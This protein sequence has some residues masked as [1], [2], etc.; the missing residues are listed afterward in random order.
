[1]VELLRAHA[2]GGASA[3]GS[4]GGGINTN[5]FSGSTSSSTSSAFG[6]PVKKQQ[7]MA[8]GEAMQKSLPSQKKTPSTSSKLLQEHPP[9]LWGVDLFP[10]WS[11]WFLVEMEKRRLEVCE[12]ERMDQRVD[13]CP[14][15]LSL[16]L[17]AFLYTYKVSPWACLSPLWYLHH[18]SA[19]S[20]IPMSYFS[21]KGRKVLRTLKYFSSQY[22]PLY[23]WPWG[24]SLSKRWLGPTSSVCSFIVKKP[25]AAGEKAT[26]AMLFARSVGK[27][28]SSDLRAMA[29]YLVEKGEKTTISWF[30]PCEFR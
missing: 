15:A 21:A 24:V 7:P 4:L 1:M 23:I 14:N 26:K 3:F 30:S 17:S 19:I 5:D 6:A 16:F 18:L 25:P 9:T 11:S 29:L 13:T 8:S 2:G 28:V 20:I 12:G 22:S 27:S 10:S